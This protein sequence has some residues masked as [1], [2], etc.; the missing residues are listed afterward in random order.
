MRPGNL[1]ADR[2]TAHEARYE[3]WLKF[4]RRLYWSDTTLGYREAGVVCSGGPTPHTDLTKT[5]VPRKCRIPPVPRSSLHVR[6]CPGDWAPAWFPPGAAGRCAK[7]L[8][9]GRHHERPSRPCSALAKQGQACAGRVACGCAQRALPR[10]GRFRN[11]P[12]LYVYWGNMCTA[13]ALC[14]RTNDKLKIEGGQNCLCNLHGGP[15]VEIS[16]TRPCTNDYFFCPGQLQ[17]GVGLFG[18]GGNLPAR[19]FTELW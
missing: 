18:G 11:K 3:A 9:G 8:G 13:Y 1:C 14:T 16:Y 10:M 4:G 7:A 2:E 12:H 6:P 15:P 5:H 19:N 17:T